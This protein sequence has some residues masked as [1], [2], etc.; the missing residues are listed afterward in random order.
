MDQPNEKTP[1]LHAGIYKIEGR[2]TAVNRP[3]EENE[4]QFLKK[5][6]IAGK[7][8]GIA[9]RVIDGESISD[10]TDR[11]EIWSFFLIVCLILLL[12]EAFLGQPPLAKEGNL[13]SSNG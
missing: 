4:S 9:P 5:G 7:L 3:K 1:A 6:E 2:L 12:G 13:I 11:S 10:S 8:P